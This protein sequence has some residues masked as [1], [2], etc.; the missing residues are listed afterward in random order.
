MVQKVEHV[1]K[2]R[3]EALALDMAGDIA[4]VGGCS[5]DELTKYLREVV[6]V[7]LSLLK[8]DS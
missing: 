8:E 6:N 3:L 7:L 5:N 4:K 2:E 1:A